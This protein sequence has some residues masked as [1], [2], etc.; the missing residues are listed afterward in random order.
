[1]TT[2]LPEY[3]WQIISTDLLELKGANFLLVVDYFSRYPEVLQLTST[4]SAMVI[5]ALQSVFAQHGIP[6]VVRS[7]NGPQYASQEFT[8]FAS[9]FEFKH[10]TSSPHYPQSNGQANS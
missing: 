1:M 6:E 9:S 4:T 3:P 7:G 10:I 8:E 2:L 5:K